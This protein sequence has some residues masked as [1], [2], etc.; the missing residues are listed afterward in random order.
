V[1]NEQFQDFRRLVDERDRELETISLKLALG[2]S[3]VFEALK[4]ISSGA[5]DVRI[6]ESSQL[7]LIAK[8]KDIVNRT[9]ENLAEIV[10]LSHE[11]AIGLAEHLDVLNGVSKGDLTARVYGTS[12]V[13]LLDGPEER[14]QPDDR[15]CVQRDHRAP[16]SSG[17]KAMPPNWKK[18]TVNRRNSPMSSHMTSKSRCV[19]W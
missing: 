18:V 13:E 16:A 5:P 10:D 8:L 9:A 2:L 7:E 4:R 1:V 14:H 12:R 15:E 19:R 3:E 6:P 17:W 11:F